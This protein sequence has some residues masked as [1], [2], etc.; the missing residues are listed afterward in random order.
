MLLATTTIGDK[1]VDML[2]STIIQGVITFKFK[3]ETWDG[4]SIVIKSRKPMTEMESVLTN[5]DKAVHLKHKQTKTS[6]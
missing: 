1:N 4:Y 2:V 3:N 5:L 6:C